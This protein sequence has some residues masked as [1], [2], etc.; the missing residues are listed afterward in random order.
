MNFFVQSANSTNNSMN[1]LLNRNSRQGAT[2]LH[3]G[4]R[5]LGANMS[6]A[7]A[8]F[9]AQ[10]LQLRQSSDDVLTSISNLRDSALPVSEENPASSEYFIVTRI[11]GTHMADKQGKLLSMADV[12]DESTG[13]TSW[14]HEFA[15]TLGD[16]VINVSVSTEEGGNIL[17]ATADAVNRDF[18]SE[19][20]A[21]I[22][23][24]QYGDSVLKFTVVS[25]NSDDYTASEN[26]N[27]TGQVSQIDTMRN[28]IE[29]FNA[30]LSAGNGRNIFEELINLIEIHENGLGLIGI[31]ANE[32]G[33]LQID[34]AHI[35]H[36][37]ESGALNQF[38]N[39]GGFINQLEKIIAGTDQNPPGLLFET[40]V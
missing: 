34:E 2:A 23:Q 37:A 17:Q 38:I 3:I 30:M 6:P 36:A 12:F 15:F 18:G 22:V 32:S 21:A 16:R 14:E 33:F 9:K 25:E 5:R 27:N 40:V 13:L 7:S 26:T 19:F 4:Q 35:A 20:H 8:A 24:N 39:S 10:L 29:S 11:S 31:S 1:A 28:F